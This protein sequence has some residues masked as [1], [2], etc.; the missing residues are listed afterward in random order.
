MS[1][2]GVFL[3]ENEITDSRVVPAASWVLI[4]ALACVTLPPMAE[5]A[6]A[7]PTL[8]VAIA[9]P[10]NHGHR[11][12]ILNRQD[13]HFHVV[14]TNVSDQPQNLWREWCSW[15]YFNL[16]F[17]VT[18][19]NGEEFTVT[20][21]M[22]EWTKNYPDFLVLGPGEH[23]VIDAYPERDWDKFPLPATGKEKKVSIQAVYEIKPDDKTKESKIW[24]GRIASEKKEYTVYN[25]K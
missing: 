9:V 23:L 2:G 3:T 19:Q 22:H 7:K 25:W 13:S 17:Q 15:G 4:V 1:G 8:A 20:K 14:V 6:D 11:A 10:E 12:I 18:D 5:G 24:T 21:K 16:L